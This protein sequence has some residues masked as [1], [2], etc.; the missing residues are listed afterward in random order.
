[1]INT[2]TTR[3]ICGI[4]TLK[5][6]EVEFEDMGSLKLLQ[7]KSKSIDMGQKSKGHHNSSLSLLKNN[8]NEFDGEFKNKGK[9]KKEEK[10]KHKQSMDLV[11][12]EEGKKKKLDFL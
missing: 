4:V 2:Q 3:Q 5:E 11:E 9:A 12:T 8:L 7:K 6:E 1:M 10:I